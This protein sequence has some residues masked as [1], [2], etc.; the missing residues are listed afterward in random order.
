MSDDP[1]RFSFG[2]PQ[3]FMPD[4]PPDGFHRSGCGH[5]VEDGDACEICHPE[6]RPPRPPVYGPHLP[7]DPETDPF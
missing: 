6:T 4:E 1:Y 2:S 5:W 7:Y 3:D